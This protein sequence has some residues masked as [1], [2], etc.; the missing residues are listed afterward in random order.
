MGTVSFG[1]GALD[2][3][4]A[5]CLLALVLAAFDGDFNHAYQSIGGGVAYVATVLLVIRPLAGAVGEG[6][7]AARQ[8]GRFRVQHLPHPRWPWAPWFTD[9]IG[10]HAVFGAFV[11][12]AAMPRG[13]VAKASVERIQ[14]FTVACSCR[15]SSPTRV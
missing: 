14:P 7:R 2:D 15:S 13:L 10:L 3:V 1:A 9:L 11:M 5:W 12:G 4:A 6:S 8:S